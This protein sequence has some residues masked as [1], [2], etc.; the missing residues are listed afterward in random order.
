MVQGIRRQV[1]PTRPTSASPPQ[2]ANQKKK[3]GC[4]R[5]V[6]IGFAVVVGFI[7]IIAGIVS[8]GS[9]KS[10]NTVT[11]GSTTTAAATQRLYPGRPDSQPKDHEAAVGQAVEFSGYTTSV[12]SAGFQQ[13]ISDYEH[14]G[15]IVATV[16]VRNRDTK[17]QS[18]NEFDFK[19][20]TPD[21]Q[22]ID[23]AVSLNDNE[24]QSGDLVSGGTVTGKVGF[25]VGNTK[26]DYFVIYKPDAFDAS[27]GI[28]KVTVT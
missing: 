27:R 9:K 3:G 1:V 7:I 11:N 17:A 26:G 16:T 14:D 10:S 21:G 6:L 8:G 12:D 18:Y 4:L 24:L 25:K 19:L 5:T 23:P 13:S 22:V 28:W 2:F 15:Y 20:Q